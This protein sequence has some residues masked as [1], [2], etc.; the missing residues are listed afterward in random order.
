MYKTKSY[1]AVEKILKPESP[2]NIFVWGESGIGK[3]SSIIDIAQ[4]LDIPYVRV[5]MSFNTEYEDLLGSVRIAG[6]ETFFE[7]GPVI[8]M[9]E[10]GGILILDECDSA[11][12]RVLFELHAVLERKPVYVKK[13]GKTITPHKNFRVIAT[14]NTNGAGDVSG[15]YGGT[16]PMNR[17]FMD[18]FDA[19]IEYESP[20]R[21]EMAAIISLTFPSVKKVVAEIVSYFYDKIYDAI[22]AGSLDINHLS[23]RKMLHLTSMYMN[24]AVDK[25]DEIYKKP[26][27]VNEIL[28]EA[29]YYAFGNMESAVI[30]AIKATWEMTFDELEELFDEF[31]DEGER[32][33]DNSLFGAFMSATSDSAG[34]PMVW[35]AY[36]K[37]VFKTIAN[38]N[39]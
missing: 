27:E 29:L 30:D 33:A 4:R 31:L 38:K 34:N 39:R 6:G 18:R 17:A 36:R 9:M 26:S 22:K 24:L 7:P 8:E 15:D 23:A 10:A 32:E 13:L 2:I 3:T 12:L 5:N 28:C 16:T 21:E 35:P 25:S 37:S 14:G 20:S 19:Y 11:D 1:F